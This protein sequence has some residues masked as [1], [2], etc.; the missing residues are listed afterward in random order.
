MTQ[1]PII[2]SE[3]PE[4]DWVGK[5][6]AMRDAYEADV[7]AE[8]ERAGRDAALLDIWLVY[9]SLRLRGTEVAIEEVEAARMTD[10][11]DVALAVS[12]ALA[13]VARIRAA[14]AAH[15]ELA[16]A[17]LVELNGLVD[18][19]GGGR[20]RTGPPVAVYQGHE[21][22]GP[23]ALDRLLENATSWFTA[24]SF[25]GEFHP[26]EQ[27]A[28]ALIRIC[29]IQPFPTNNEMT[30]RIA[31]SLF[32]LEAGWPPLIVR[33]EYELEYRKAVIHAMHLDTR[34]VVELIAK[35]VARAYDELMHWG[36]DSVVSGQ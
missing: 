19:V 13:A 20:L 34:L 3:R 14:A 21:A 29:D 22:P 24:V 1:L 33:D 12:G 18:P 28:L 26:V 25:T 32:L 36:I 4:Y 16:P 17:L 15:E 7:Q 35:C 5:L 30:A 10:A 6:K 31:V 23:E 2:H 9:H 27:A 8:P 11:G